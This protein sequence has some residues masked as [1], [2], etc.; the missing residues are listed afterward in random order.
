[1]TKFVDVSLPTD[2]WGSL[3][4]HSC[5]IAEDGSAYCW[6]R[7]AS[8][9]LGDGLQ[10]N[11]PFPVK[12]AG[13]QKWHKLAL[14]PSTTC[15]LTVDG[16]IY[17]WGYGPN[18]ELGNGTNGPSAINPIPQL[19]T[20]SNSD[21][22]FRDLAATN[23]GIC[24][25][26]MS[27]IADD[28]G[29]LYCW[30]RKD[31]GTI[32]S[33]SNVH[34]GAGKIT[35]DAMPYLNVPEPLHTLRRYK[36]LSIGSASS[37]CAIDFDDVAWC[38]GHGMYGRLGTGY[39]YFIS[40]ANSISSSYLTAPLS[41]DGSGT[42]LTMTSVAVGFYSYVFV[43]TKLKTSTKFKKIVNEQNA[44]CGIAIDDSVWCWGRTDIGTSG[45]L[46]RGFVYNTGTCNSF[47]TNAASDPTQ[48]QICI[49]RVVGY[50]PFG[51]YEPVQIAPPGQFKDIAA[52]RSA[53]IG[54]RK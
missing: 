31:H 35:F 13:D 6:G 24:G 52:A 21:V 33:I 38:W 42:P 15:G 1:M 8:G 12:V 23:V 11:Q 18:G 2:S 17:C 45:P 30:G 51:V 48:R 27:E 54:I 36:S 39:R 28:D 37:Q 47:L 41:V 16:K 14:S 26:T 50:G 44:G 49:N 10:T 29:L 25:L 34:G 9:Q 32:D 43:P 3:G 53:F 20:P 5:A 46:G 40:E 7:G 4:A 19:V 22:E